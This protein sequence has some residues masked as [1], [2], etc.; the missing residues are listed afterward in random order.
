MEINTER[1]LL[2]PLNLADAETVL[3]YRSDATANQYQGWIPKTIDDVHVFIRDRVSPA[4]DLVG[5][6]Y[7][8]VMIKKESGELVGDIG[9]HFLDA[10]RKQAELGYTLDKNQQGKGYATE[11]L[12]KIINYLFNELNKRRIVTSIDPRNIKSIALVKRLGFRKEAHFKESILQNGEWVDDLVYAILKDEWIEKSLKISI[13]LEKTDLPKSNINSD[14]IK[15]QLGPCGIYCG[16]CFA[17][18]DGAI[19]HHSSELLKALGNFEPYAN[20]FITL[21]E[22]P[23]FAKYPDFK[24]LLTYFTR[25]WC[26][27]CRNDNCK[28]FKGCKVKECSRTKAVDFCFQCPEFPCENT[29]FDVNLRNRWLPI[30]KR[31]KE[32]GVERYF[33]EIKGNSR[34]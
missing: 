29:G 17:F 24:E 3:K 27:G 25:G 15:Q 18:S 23:L 28:L 4:I 6:W 7:Q 10:D 32:V 16:K 30:N 1:L 19:K 31:M 14:Q 22:E 33:E 11:A 12:V 20:R 34:Y 5:T 8:F 2:R 21:L 9:I 13:T 26:K